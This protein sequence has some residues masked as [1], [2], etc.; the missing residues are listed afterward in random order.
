M[1]QIEVSETPLM[2]FTRD[3]YHVRKFE[4]VWE[5]EGYEDT[6]RCAM[7]EERYLQTR[8]AFESRA[9]AGLSAA[10]AG[11]VPTPT[12]EEM[13][14]SGTRVGKYPPLR[15]VMFEL[16][17]NVQPVIE[18]GKP[19]VLASLMD[20]KGNYSFIRQA[21]VNNTAVDEIC[22]RTGAIGDTKTSD[23]GISIMQSDGSGKV[24]TFL[25]MTTLFK[26]DLAVLGIMEPAKFAKFGPTIMR[27]FAM[28]CVSP[29]PQPQ[30]TPAGTSAPSIPRRRN[31][32]SL[33][34]GSTAWCVSAD[35]PDSPSTK[36]CAPWACRCL[37][38]A[39]SPFS[40]RGSKSAT[41][42]TACASPRTAGTSTLA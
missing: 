22:I 3:M 2:Q 38:S 13:M 1:G 20:C 36:S 16:N 39:P 23:L 37:R 10:A 17:E 14:H 29:P 40:R 6:V 26:E 9:I 21:N 8:S 35:T 34:P 42:P 11:A 31:R 32:L 7:G 24:E 25:A 19:F 27:V 4:R 41:P 18:D 28:E 15:A 30:L 12:E 33:P 5:C